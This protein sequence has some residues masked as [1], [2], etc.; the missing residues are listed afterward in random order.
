MTENDKEATAKTTKRCTTLRD[1][2]KDRSRRSLQVSKVSEEDQLDEA[3][4]VAQR[5]I[6]RI[7]HEDQARHAVAQS[8]NAVR[9]VGHTSLPQREPRCQILPQQ[10]VVHKL[11]VAPDDQRKYRRGDHSRWKRVPTH[12]EVVV[13]N[14]V[15]QSV[16]VE[17]F[18]IE[19]VR[20]DPGDYH[21]KDQ[22]L[23]ACCSVVLRRVV[24]LAHPPEQG[25]DGYASVARRCANNR[26][27]LIMNSMMHRG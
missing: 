1:G 13:A 21:G 7:E 11:N 2:T 10:V 6:H 16:A 23:T 8:R 17:H 24:V 18:I 19:E 27:P 26:R 20:Q 5:V 4:R 25:P 9:D 15:L 12:A 14:S 22:Q 3:D